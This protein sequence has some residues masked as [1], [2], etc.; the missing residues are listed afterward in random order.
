[1]RGRPLEGPLSAYVD[2]VRQHAYRVTDEDL[3]TLRRS[4]LSEDMIFEVTVAAAL[5][6]GLVRLRVGLAALQAPGDGR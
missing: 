3:A 6:A 1:M 4:G 2:K 5:G